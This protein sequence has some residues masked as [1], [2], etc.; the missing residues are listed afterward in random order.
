MSGV[1]GT[2]NLLSEEG[3][4]LIFFLNVFFRPTSVNCMSIIEVLQSRAL[5]SCLQLTVKSKCE[6]EQ[7]LGGEGCLSV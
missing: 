5:H 7:A 1:A 2:F 6:R 3:V 4:N